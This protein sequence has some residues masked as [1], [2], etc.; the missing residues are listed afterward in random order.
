MT[1]RSPSP[2]P[3]RRNVKGLST[4]ELREMFTEVDMDSSGTI[5]WFELQMALPGTAPPAQASYN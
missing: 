2:N 3:R 5:N 1:S 4:A